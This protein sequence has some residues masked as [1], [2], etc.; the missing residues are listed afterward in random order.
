M[1]QL[2]TTELVVFVAVAVLY[3]AAAV[4]A[5]RQI[6]AGNKE[7]QAILAHLFALGAVGE[8]VILIFRAVAIRA[9]PL[10]GLFESMIVLTLVLGLLYLVFGIVIRQ[11]WFSC[12]MSWLILLMIILTALVAKPAVRPQ[13]IATEPWVVAHALAMILGAAM[14]LL[15][16]VAAYLYLLG[17]RRLKGKQITKVLGTVPNIQKLARIDVWALK[18]AFLLFTVGLVSGIVGV[19]FKAG[20]LGASPARWLVDS[21]IIGMVIVWIVL[22]AIMVL[23]RLH[24]IRGK[25][26]AYATI[27]ALIWIVFAFVGAHLLCRTKHEFYYGDPCVPLPRYETGK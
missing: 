25:R 22:A 9:I 3:F 5:T 10:T 1:F 6:R 20:V 15:A 21:K 11:I 26:I 2:P 16:G 17:S 7:R 13:Q 19:F 24:L 12:V 27:V 4:A 18:A 23:R 14:L 8:A